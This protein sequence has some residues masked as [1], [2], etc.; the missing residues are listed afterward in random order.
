M[1][2]RDQF[3]VKFYFDSKNLMVKF[4]RIGPKSHSN[5]FEWIRPSLVHSE[6]LQI[7]MEHWD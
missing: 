2:L 6:G 5:E 3:Q 4:N 7:G 1:L